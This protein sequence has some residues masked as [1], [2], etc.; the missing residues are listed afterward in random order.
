M[1]ASESNATHERRVGL[2]LSTYPGRP[3]QIAHAVGLDAL[4][5]ALRIAAA[6]K[7]EGYAVSGVPKT[8]NDLVTRL[9]ERVAISV[10][11]CRL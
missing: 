6:L 9:T 7:R 11:G 10:A 1:G 2:M 3:D 8:T 5:S 4:E